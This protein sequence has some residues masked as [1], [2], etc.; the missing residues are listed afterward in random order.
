MR[1]GP[2][3]SIGDGADCL[4]GSGCSRARAGM[5]RGDGTYFVGWLSRIAI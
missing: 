5:G 2:V 3:A 4:L 1:T